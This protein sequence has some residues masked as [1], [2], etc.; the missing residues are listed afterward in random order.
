MPG[1][2]NGD[3]DITLRT[4]LPPAI[5]IIML[6]EAA[7]L[8]YCGI[9][10]PN[11]EGA[12]SRARDSARPAARRP[13]PRN[14][15]GAVSVL[16]RLQRRLRDG[17]R[18]PFG[19]KIHFLSRVRFTNSI[20]AKGDLAPENAHNEG[21]EHG[22]KTRI[23]AFVRRDDKV[24]SCIIILSGNAS[25]MSNQYRFAQSCPEL[26]GLRLIYYIIYIFILRMY[27]I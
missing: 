3:L 6:L 5:K 15:T 18:V 8:R 24:S 20:M 1:R 14:R 19:T 17:E 23:F 22:M 9:M 27:I 11:V 12:E 26:G 25:L 7:M 21:V 2:I 13:G 16:G 4:C 10:A